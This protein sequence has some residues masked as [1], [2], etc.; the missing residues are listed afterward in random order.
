MGAH[1]MSFSKLYSE[2]F[3]VGSAATSA[4]ECNSS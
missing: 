2:F 4:A 1:L 3:I